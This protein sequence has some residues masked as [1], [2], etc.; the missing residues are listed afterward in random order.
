MTSLKHQ[1][2]TRL[3]H[4]WSL[5]VHL[6]L[7]QELIVLCYH[8]ISDE[9]TPLLFTPHRT[10]QKFTKDLEAFQKHYNLVSSQQVL[11]SI[12]TGS[13][14][15]PRALLLTFDDGHAECESI[16][17]PILAAKG[18][19]A[20]FF[21]TTSFLDNC[22]IHHRH[23]AAL[24]SNQCASFTE[25]KKRQLR[26]EIYPEN[27]EADLLQNIRSTQYAQKQKLFQLASK[28]DFDLN[29]YL[30]TKTPYLSKSQVKSLLNSGFEIGGHSVDHPIFAGLPLAEQVRQTLDCMRELKSEF[31][32]H[33][34]FFAFPNTDEK[35]SLNYFNEVYSSGLIDLT[36]GTRGIFFQDIPKN[37]QRATIENQEVS[38]EKSLGFLYNVNLIRRA[39]SRT[40]IRRAHLS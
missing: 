6:V 28:I 24:M 1:I 37:I 11:D 20:T 8:L 14:L 7:R 10:T 34:G 36:F 26:D 35:V 38:V 29:D 33:N 40:R 30:K 27:K 32:I 13:S 15:P 16:V 19:P 22:N 21:L 4:H 5:P 39:L 2:I 18:I 17:A 9:D 31:G 25:T 12:R 3:P 23:L